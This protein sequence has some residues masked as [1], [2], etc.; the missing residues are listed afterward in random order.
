MKSNEVFVILVLIVALGVFAIPFGSPKFLGEAIALEVA[1]VI[2]AALIWRGYSKALYACIALGVLVILG[3]TLSPA[4][5]K[6]MTT[7]SKPI[8]ALILI[9]GGYI[10]AGV[11]VYTGMKAIIKTKH[12][13]KLV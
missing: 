10:L 3:N 11:L 1:F 9:I 12:P 7:F 6:L 5:V 4:H 2:L 8:N 13:V